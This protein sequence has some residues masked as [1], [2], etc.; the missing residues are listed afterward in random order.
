M[1]FVFNIVLKTNIELRSGRGIILLEYYYILLEFGDV[2]SDVP[3]LFKLSDLEV[4]NELLVAVS[5]NLDNSFLESI[6]SIKQ[7]T[8]IVFGIRVD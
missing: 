7:L 4:G 8:S 1:D 6:L 5:E 3:L 2:V